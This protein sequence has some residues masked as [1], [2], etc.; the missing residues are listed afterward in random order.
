MNRHRVRST[1]PKS[2]RHPPADSGGTKSGNARRRVQIDFT[3]EDMNRLGEL[4]KL[5]GLKSKAELL[6][7]AIRL[8]EWYVEQK[9]KG[10]SIALRKGG[11]F[12]QVEVLF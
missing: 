4:A 9:Q 1:S 5:E 3:D 10:Y 12:R 2:S 6:R 8:F 11:R 7:N